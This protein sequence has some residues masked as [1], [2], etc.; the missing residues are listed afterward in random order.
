MITILGLI[1]TQLA[2]AAVTKADCSFTYMGYPMAQVQLGFSEAFVPNDFVTVVQQGRSH[3]E[4]FTATELAEG[5]LARGWISQEVPDNTVELIIYREPQKH[6]QA[7][8]V[9][10]Q[11]PFGKEVWA[12][13]DFL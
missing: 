13:C 4:S 9:N 1:W 6:G 5:E 12:T 7:K 10:H 2:I 11:V 3:L 8:M